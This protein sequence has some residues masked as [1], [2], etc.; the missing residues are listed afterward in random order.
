MDEGKISKD[1]I[2]A[3]ILYLYIIP[4]LLLYYKVLPENFRFGMLLVISILLLGIVRHSKWTHKDMGIDKDFMRDIVPYSIFTLGGVLFLIWL[5]KIVPH[6]PFLNWWQNFR[7]LILFIPISVLQEVV[8][9]GIL[10]NMLGKVFS[11]PFF[12][13]FVNALIFSMMHVIYLNSIFVLPMTFIAGIGFAWMY[14][15]YKNLPLIS[16]SHTI[17]N[18]VA[19]VLGFFIVR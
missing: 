8:F 7:F 19:M 13:I 2:W 11:N 6:D 14:Y 16:I 10:M 3:Q 12:I 4:V 1:V 18:F 9:R 17:L 5:A 15:K